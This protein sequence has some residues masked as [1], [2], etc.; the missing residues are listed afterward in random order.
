MKCNTETNSLIGE[1]LRT[2]RK[3]AGYSQ[4]SLINELQTHGFKAPSRNTLSKIEGGNEDAIGSL[5][6]SSI[7]GMSLLFGCDPGFLLGERDYRNHEVN[8]IH[9]K[10]GLSDAAIFKLSD[11]KD[12]GLS[13]V[14]S[15]CL[16]GNIEF[17]LSIISGLANSGSSGTQQIN[18]DGH[19]MNISN[20]RM[21][22]WFFLDHMREEIRTI[23]KNIANSEQEASR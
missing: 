4:E 3:E 20:A 14:L 18:I 7:V 21:L 22:E 8:L 6:L 19:E 17:F 1:R 2:A 12:N 11:I 13:S 9:D 15:K 23:A 10:T 5:S 16:E